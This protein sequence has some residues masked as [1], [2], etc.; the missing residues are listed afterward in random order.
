MKDTY[1][2][3]NS[4]NRIKQT[5]YNISKD[6]N[7]N[8]INLTQD[9][10]IITIN[11]PDH[12]FNQNDNIKLQINPNNTYQNLDNPFIFKLYNSQLYVYTY[13]PNIEILLILITIITLIYKI[14][15]ILK[16]LLIFKFYKMILSSKYN[17]IIL[18]QLMVSH[19]LTH[20][21]N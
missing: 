17:L 6:Y 8:S 14:F 16:V 7:V 5:Q 20:S 1:I 9:S 10:N 4:K 2:T 15:I 13:H 3:F 18:P 11:H 21:L 12:G 19:L